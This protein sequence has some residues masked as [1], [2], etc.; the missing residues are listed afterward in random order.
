[1]HT[2]VQ[3]MSFKKKLTDVVSD[4][5]VKTSV[6]LRMFQGEHL[7]KQAQTHYSWRKINSFTAKSVHHSTQQSS[8]DRFPMPAVCKHRCVWSLSPAV[9]DAIMEWCSAKDGLMKLKVSSW[10]CCAAP[11]THRGTFTHNRTQTVIKAD[12]AKAI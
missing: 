6:H 5:D 9:Q 11:P 12:G 2:T 4:G 1:M 8:V 3:H 7:A 10:Q